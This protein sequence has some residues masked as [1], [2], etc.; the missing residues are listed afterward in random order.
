MIWRYEHPER[1]FP[2]YSSAAVAAGKVVLGGRDK[3]VH[4]LNASTGKPVWS[5]P[6]RA[7]VDSSPAISE[8]RVY[9]GSNDGRL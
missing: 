8:G 7:R 1:K 3:L 9:I 6:T 5:F 4:C 2:F